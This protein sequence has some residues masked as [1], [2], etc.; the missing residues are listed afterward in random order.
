MLT[1]VL[2]LT[3]KELSYYYNW[4]IIIELSLSNP[5]ESIAFCYFS[6]QSA[7]GMRKLATDI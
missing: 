1:N 5:T 2:I 6:V 3:Y 7:W 4:T